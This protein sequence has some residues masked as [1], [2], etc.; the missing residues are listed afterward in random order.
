MRRKI[1][2]PRHLDT[3]LFVSSSKPSPLNR[4]GCH[5]A[6]RPRLRRTA[7]GSDTSYVTD[8]IYLGAGESYDAI[9][10]AP[11]KTG[12]GYDTYL[13]FNNALG[14]LNKPNNDPSKTGLGLGG[15]MTEVRVYAAGALPLQTAP[16]T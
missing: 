14:S 4:Q 13:L 11:P 15:Q 2:A 8:T 1:S 16:N 3:R 9:F 12:S 7:H 10:T 5:A 6:A